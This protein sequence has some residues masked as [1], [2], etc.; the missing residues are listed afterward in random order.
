MD[1]YCSNR[2][3]SIMKDPR[4]N[5]AIEKEVLTADKFYENLCNIA[6]WRLAA[7]LRNAKYCRGSLDKAFALTGHSGRWL[8]DIWVYIVNVMPWFL[9]ATFFL[10]P[11]LFYELVAIVSTALSSVAMEEMIFEKTI[12]IPVFFFFNITKTLTQ[13]VMIPVVHA[14]DIRVSMALAGSIVLIGLLCL[15]YI[16]KAIFKFEL[17]YRRNLLMKRIAKG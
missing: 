15:S 5:A 11:G 6:G 7:I 10:I 9:P 12:K 13:K 16:T 1:T 4:L 3:F 14:P 2:I 8:F 17:R